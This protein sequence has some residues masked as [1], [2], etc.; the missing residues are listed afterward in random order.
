[1]RVRLLALLTLLA[2]AASV[3]PA[4]AQRRTVK[5]TIPAGVSFF[6]TDAGASTPATGGPMRISFTEVLFKKN[7]NFTISVKADTSTFSGPGTTRIPASAVSWTASTTS[8]VA[9][10]GTLSSSAY[11]QVYQSPR[12]PLE[13][14]VDV[15]WL[16]GPIAA[17]GLRA[18][19]HV[20]TVRWRLETL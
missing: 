16:L 2:C 14:Q 18:G 15:S 1:M 19:T 20:I 5:V 11:S 17:P 3:T 10:G 6:V 4:F 12:D 13:G 7:D 9:T 8:G